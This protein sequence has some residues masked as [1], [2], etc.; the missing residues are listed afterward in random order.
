MTIAKFGEIRIIITYSTNTISK[1]GLILAETW[2]F[3][4]VEFNWNRFLFI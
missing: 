2:V 1:K 4:S 3:A